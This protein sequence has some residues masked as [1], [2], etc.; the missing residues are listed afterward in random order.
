MKKT[1]KDLAKQ[2]VAASV[3][4]CLFCTVCLTACS[5]DDDDAGDQ[6]EQPADDEGD[7]QTGSSS[8]STPTNLS[9]KQVTDDGGNATSSVVLSWDEVKGASYYW[10]YYNTTDD[11]SSA[12]TLSKKITDTY[13]EA[14]LSYDGNYYFWVKTADGTTSKSNTSDF[15]EGCTLYVAFSSFLDAPDDIT[16][17]LPE[18]TLNMVTLS[19]TKVSDVSYYSIYYNTT[20]DSS[21]A[22][23]LEKNVST[24]SKSITLTESGTYY[25]W[26][27]SQSGY[28]YLSASGVDTSDFSESTDAITFTY[29]NLSTPE[30]VTAEQTSNC[31][32]E[33]SWTD[34][35]AAY[36]WVYYSTTEDTSC[37]TLRT[38]TKNAYVTIS[39]SES[40][41]YYFW[42][43]S[44]N[45]NSDDDAVSDFSEV[46]SIDFTYST[47]ATPTNVI[48]AETNL[49]NK[50]KVTWDDVGSYFYRVYYNT[51]NSTDGATLVSKYISGYCYYYV[52][53]SSSGTYYFWVQGAEGTSDSA[54][55]GDFSEVASIDFTYSEE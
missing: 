39:L 13:Y 28:W 36:Y 54:T 25:F 45:G 4:L 26:V 3:C 49:T 20:D 10:V 2:L 43:K 53:L 23:L 38:K 44:A 22:T 24:T 34:N 31:T 8:L 18:D 47:P 41:T 37:A 33:V 17:T 16:A 19:W 27:K 29:S 46:A 40:A 55:L 11:S 35:N 30:N 48:V 52:A 51:E 9:A 21:T 14:I 15:S 7:N 50:V 5:D 6:T 32:I 42:I 12:T 1:H